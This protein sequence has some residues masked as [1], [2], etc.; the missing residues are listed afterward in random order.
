MPNYFHNKTNDLIIFF[1]PSNSSRSAELLGKSMPN[2]VGFSAVKDGG[3]LPVL[4][5]LTIGTLNDVEIDQNFQL[6][7][8]KMNKKDATTKF[9]VKN[10]S[11]K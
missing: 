4:P 8:K 1:Q 9:K 11:H 2:F 3:Y 5:G 10:I 7:F 6:V